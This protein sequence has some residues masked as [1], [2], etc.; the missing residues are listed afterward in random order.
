MRSE[1]R[2]SLEVFRGHRMKTVQLAYMYVASRRKEELCNYS[3]DAH[4]MSDLSSMG[5]V[6]KSSSVVDASFRPV[7]VNCTYKSAVTMR[8]P[9]PKTFRAQLS[10]LRRFTDPHYSY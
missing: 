10:I 8:S 6:F 1:N 3:F 5:S 7:T 9:A 2:W 4:F